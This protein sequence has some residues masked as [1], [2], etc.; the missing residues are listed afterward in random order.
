MATLYVDASTGDDSRSY[1]TAQNPATPWETIYRAAKGAAPGE[2]DD[3]DECAQAGD[4]VIIVGSGDVN[5]PRLYTVNTAI[6]DNFLP[7]YQPA[8]TGTSGSP[9]TFQAQGY[10]KLGAPA[11][12]APVVGTGTA[13]IDHFRWIADRADSRF[14]IVC[15]G[16]GGATADT[17]G[18]TSVVNTRPDSGPV[19]ISGDGVHIIGFDIDGGPM[20]DYGDNWEG[21]R[22][23]NGQ[24]FVIRNCYIHDFRKDEDSNAVE[25][26]SHNQ[27]GIT[28]Y[29]AQNGL[30]EHNLLENNGTGIYFKDTA[31]LDPT[32]NNIV[33]LN[34]IT[35]P[36][37]KAAS[38]SPE[39][40][41]WSFT[42]TGVHTANAIY[43]NVLVDL[44]F[45]F[46][47]AQ[48]LD[49]GDDVY[50]NTV[51]RTDIGFY[52][53]FG[54]ESVRVWNTIMSVTQAA[55]YQDNA[56]TPDD[57][58]TDFEHNVYVGFG[59]GTFMTDNT[60]NHSFAQW[61]SDY[62]SQDHA[63]PDSINDDP[64]FVDADEDDFTLEVTSP[65]R[66]LGRHPD[67]AATMHAGA[68]QT[69]DE[70]IGLTDEDAE[71]PA[72]VDGAGHPVLLLAVL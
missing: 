2:A 5:S 27:T 68:Y 48:T 45:G 6:D 36:E 20:I 25:D 14:I 43:Q 1:A 11:A 70:Q 13:S 22:V 55:I 12:N 47:V 39:G 51:A 67:T 15:D 10:V 54:G 31:L 8:V 24:N 30:I 23:Q 35:S 57:T 60:G 40:I 16:R 61:L 44:T 49:G 28:L 38:R 69:M 50:N 59:A 4:T 34:W 32:E 9:I 21:I 71:P 56:A 17:K 58:A 29:G 33:R 72:E 63:D 46:F 37:V 26:T 7:V 3:T 18:D 64:E 66:D 42:V 53:P 62:P 41:T 65:A 52:G 19:V